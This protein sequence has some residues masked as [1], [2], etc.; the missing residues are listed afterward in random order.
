[1]NLKGTKEGIFSLEL[2]NNG[3]FPWPK[4]KTFL[5]FDDSKE[6]INIHKNVL[7]PLN[8]GYKTEVIIILNNLDKINLGKYYICLVF[9]VDGREYGDTLLVNIE[10]TDNINKNKHKTI[11]KALRNEYDFTN[12]M[13]SNTMI[14]DALEEFKTFEGAVDYML[15]EKN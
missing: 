5:E 9:K 2:E 6:N 8:P 11:I 13:F 15:K 10:V 12:T 14:G 3:S 7:V 1:M 4:N